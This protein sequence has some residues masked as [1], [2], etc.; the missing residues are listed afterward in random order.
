M[1]VNSRFPS[2]DSGRHKTFSCRELSRAR[3]AIIY[4]S[5]ASWLAGSRALFANSRSRARL[6]FFRRLARSATMKRR[7]VPGSSEKFSNSDAGTSF[8]LSV[9]PAPFLLYSPA[10]LL[11]RDLGRDQMT[12]P[13]CNTRLALDFIPVSARSSGRLMITRQVANS[14]AMLFIAN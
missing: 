5:W 11:F 7:F 3:S 1:T 10:H 12:R 14:P 8:F 4:P 6:G 9:L 2:H 13:K